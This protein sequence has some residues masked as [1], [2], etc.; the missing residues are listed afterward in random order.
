MPIQHVGRPVKRLE[1]P[2]L[3]TG[4]DRYVNDVRLEGA[5]QLAF[6]RS[7]TPHAVLKRDRHRAASEVPGVVAGPDRAPT[8]TPRSASSTRRSRPRCSPR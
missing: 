4:A 5:L 3:I 8:S 7:P 1:D 6:V 2:K